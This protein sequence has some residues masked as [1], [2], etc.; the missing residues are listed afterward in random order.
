M[1]GRKA[2]GQQVKMYCKGFCLDQRVRADHPLRDVKKLIDF[3]F[4]YKEVE[5]TYGIKGH[6][7]VPPPVIL[8]LM[9]LLVFYNVRSE[10]ELVATLPERIDWLWFID[11]DLDEK[12]PD[13]SVL[14]KARSRWGKNVF[15]AFFERIV[16][17]CVKAGLVDGSKIFMDSSLVRAD[18]SERSVVDINSLKLD[19]KFKEFEDRLEDLAEKGG[20]K[21]INGSHLSTTDPDASIVSKRK[22]RSQLSYK[23]HRAVDEKTEVI[24]ATEITSGAVNEGHLLSDL[25]KQHEENTTTQVEIVVADSEYG[26]AGNYLGC[27]DQGVKAHIPPFREKQSGD[28]FPNEKFSYDPGSD[29]HLCPAG[30]RLTCR[31]Y[32]EERESFQYQCKAGI[33]KACVLRDKCT[34]AE[35]GRTIRRHLRHDEIELMR[36]RV[37]TPSAKEDINTRQHLMERSFARAVRFGFKRARWRRLWR[38][39]IQEYLTATIQNIIVLIRNAGTAWQM[40]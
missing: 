32:D 34:K 40:G 13:H 20:T 5:R 8:K 39:K 35:G 7:S 22:V 19:D 18:A 9:L 16:R 29:S 33:C 15:E 14:S 4:T 30:E 23:V 26:T 2:K 21:G 37:Q 11:F 12:I 38:V 24:T 36:E 25:T 6:V 3:D 17:Q 1:M 10:R 31:R 28:F 27:L